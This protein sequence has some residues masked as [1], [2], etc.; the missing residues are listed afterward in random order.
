MSTVQRQEA[1]IQALASII[2]TV[3]RTW[4]WWAM[5]V[6]QE[7][8][9]DHRS[10]WSLTL[11]PELLLLSLDSTSITSSSF[12]IPVTTRTCSC[13][14]RPEWQKP[15]RAFTEKFG[16]AANFCQPGKD[17]SSI[18]KDANV[19][20]LTFSDQKKSTKSTYFAVFPHEPDK[21]I[22][23]KVFTSNQ[24]SEMY[25]NLML[26]VSTDTDDRQC[27][28]RCPCYLLSF[29]SVSYQWSL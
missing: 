16:K 29:S 22:P 17:F 18:C 8:S 28:L 27:H 20:V 12:Y 14:Q 19:A 3:W 15:R 13:L 4:G 10:R 7:V 23:G 9:P 6:G 1:C 26:K 5:V 21:S 2:S 11:L 24:I 25:S